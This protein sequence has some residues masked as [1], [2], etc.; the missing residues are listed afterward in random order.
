MLGKQRRFLSLQGEP[1]GHRQPEP[2]MH[3]FS[4]GL[5]AKGAGLGTEGDGQQR[6]MAIYSLI[7]E[8]F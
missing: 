1:P 8:S 3:A 6:P 4:P 7:T 2:G 5:V